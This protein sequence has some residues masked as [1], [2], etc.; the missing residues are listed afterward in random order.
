MLAT[1]E[2]LGVE[3]LRSRNEEPPLALLL[4]DSNELSLR[5]RC[6]GIGDAFTSLER[7]LGAIW[8]MKCE[9]GVVQLSRTFVMYNNLRALVP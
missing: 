7:K 3:G 5:S 2:V 1:G 9:M 6:E 4:G 8:Y